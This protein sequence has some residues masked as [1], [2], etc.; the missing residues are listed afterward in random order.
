MTIQ[1]VNKREY[2]TPSEVRSILDAALDRK[3]RYSHRD[4]TRSADD[5]PPRSKGRGSCRL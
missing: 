4:Y 2:F 1:L 5:V 3:A